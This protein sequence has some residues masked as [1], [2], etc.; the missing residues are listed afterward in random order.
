MRS[1]VRPNTGSIP[2]V[3]NASKPRPAHL[4]V[5]T[6]QALSILGVSVKVFSVG[7]HAAS[8]VGNWEGLFLVITLAALGEGFNVCSHG[9]VNAVDA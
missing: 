4:R 9:L 6:G 8:Q 3:I 2:L 5:L 1:S 7:D